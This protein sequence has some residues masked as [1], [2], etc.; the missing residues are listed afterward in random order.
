MPQIELSGAEH[1]LLA[2]LA[3]ST[4]RFSQPGRLTGASDLPPEVRNPIFAAFQSIAR[5]HGLDARDCRFQFYP[6]FGKSFIL[7]GDQQ[8]AHLR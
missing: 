6:E 2:G 7:T 5:A 4:D 1:S 3:G 8:V